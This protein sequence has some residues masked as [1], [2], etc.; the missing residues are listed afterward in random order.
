MSPASIELPLGLTLLTFGS[1]FGVIKWYEAYVSGITTPLGTIM[2]ATLPILIGFQLVLAFLA[3][4]IA[5]APRIPLQ[6][7]LGKMHSIFK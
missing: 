6:Y 1:V 4:D 7:T 5:N 2:L 3:F